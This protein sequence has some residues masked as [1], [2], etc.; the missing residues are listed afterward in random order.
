[1]PGDGFAAP[2][3]ATIVDCYLEA[4]GLGRQPPS[5]GFLEA[6]T[7]RHV[8]TFPFASVGPRLGEELPLDLPSLHDRICVRRRGG[9]CF[10]QNGLLYGVLEELGFRVTLCLCRV[11]L[12]RP[13]YP[14]LTHRISLVEIDGR[15]WIA[16]VGF[17]MFGPRVP[18]ALD[19]E[20]SPDFDAVFHTMTGP[21]GQRSLV[22]DRRDGPL[23]LYAFDL[24]RYGEADC[25]VGHFWSHRSPKA[26]FVNNL[27]VSRLLPGETRYLRNR[28]YR[29][30]RLGEEEVRSVDDA[31]GLRSVLVGDMG[32]EVTEGECE[33]LFRAME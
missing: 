33:R 26:N 1:M 20:P 4:L 14:G 11:I 5:L 23:T 30:A 6:I 10:E 27:I 22:A 21:D 2:D 16:D 15:R 25:E 28:E 24:V 8:A 29:V 31:G 7:A 9:Y 12:N 13:I 18:V 32:L 19:G 3:R 17:G